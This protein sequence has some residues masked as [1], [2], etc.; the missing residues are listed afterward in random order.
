MGTDDIYLSPEEYN[1]GEKEGLQVDTAL[2]SGEKELMKVS[3][4]EQ[5]ED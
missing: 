3:V 2:K 1:T 4:K 5:L